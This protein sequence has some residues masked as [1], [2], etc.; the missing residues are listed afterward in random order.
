MPTDLVNR[1][2]GSYQ[3]V[4]G[5][6]SPSDI[7]SVINLGAGSFQVTGRG[8]D[9]GAGRMYSSAKIAADGRLDLLTASAGDGC[10]K[11]DEGLYPWSLSEGGL[12]LTIE[13]GTDAC[14]TR[15]AVVPGERF[16]IAVGCPA[17]QWCLGAIV[18]GSHASGWFQPRGAGGGTAKV[19]TGAL[20][21]DVPA[22]WANAFDDYNTYSLM[23]QTAF[24]QQIAEPDAFPDQILV[25]A[26][27][28][29]LGSVFPAPQR[30]TLPSAGPR[31]NS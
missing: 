9:T 17:G 8:N 13:P 3:N 4:E 18:A 5:F 23:P 10:V 25:H 24:Q 19:A 28:A 11:G 7:A 29:A 22:G 30:Q 27:P 2:V 12:K 14:A 6:S 1:W 21:Y 20:T 16:G 15:A 31:M 26:R